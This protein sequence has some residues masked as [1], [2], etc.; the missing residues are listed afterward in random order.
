MDE[1]LS[2]ASRIVTIQ[3]TPVPLLDCIL[4]LS[5]L[6]HWQETKRQERLS[7]LEEEWSGVRELCKQMNRQ[8]E[9]Q[10]EK[11]SRLRGEKVPIWTKDSTTVQVWCIDTCSMTLPM[12]PHPL[13]SA[14]Q[15]CI[16]KS[17]RGGMRYHAH[18]P[19]GRFKVQCRIDLFCNSSKFPLLF[20]R[21]NYSPIILISN[22]H[23]LVY[24]YNKNRC[25][26]K[27]VLCSMMWYVTLQDLKC[28]HYN[29]LY[30]TVCL[31]DIWAWI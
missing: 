18:D 8:E 31:K 27:A 6:N 17:G 11:L 24:M 16:Q 10:E 20:Q 5:V 9:E 25:M 7:R 22:P 13:S 21:T 19:K 12:S 14:F 30:A 1:T 29:F 2:R 15:Y 3:S 4:T 23:L 28:E 26:H